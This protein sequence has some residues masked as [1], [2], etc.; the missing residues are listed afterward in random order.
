MFFPFPGFGRNG[1]NREDIGSLIQ[2]N[3]NWRRC[4]SGLKIPFN[5]SAEGAIYISHGCSPWIKYIVSVSGFWPKWRLSRKYG[6][7]KTIESQ[8]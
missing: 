6:F 4:F 1:V 5:H 8:L 7:A 3:L 2:L